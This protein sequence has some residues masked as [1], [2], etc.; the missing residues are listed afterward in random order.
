VQSC[1]RSDLQAFL[2]EVLAIDTGDAPLS[3]ECGDSAQPEEVAQPDDDAIPWRAECGRGRDS[4]PDGTAVPD[5]TRL[6]HDIYVEIRWSTLGAGYESGDSTT[7]GADIDLHV[8]HPKACL[9]EGLDIDGDGLCDPWYDVPWD[10][11]VS[12]PHP[13]WGQQG[14]TFDDPMMVPSGMGSMDVEVA[15]LDS[16]EPVTY[17]VAVFYSDSHGLGPSTAEVRVYL[18]GK[19][20]LEEVAELHDDP[21]WFDLWHVCTITWPT[22]TAELIVDDQGKPWVAPYPKPQYYDEP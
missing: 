12:N 2:P 18:Q 10:C 21:A 11:Y 19:L 6:Q 16:P 22:M 15:V 17:Q 7:V 1:V 20:A 8:V 9:V 3:R 5:A 13:D 4:V 14:Q